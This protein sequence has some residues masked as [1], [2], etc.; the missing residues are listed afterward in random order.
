MISGDSLVMD[1]LSIVP[2]SLFLF[3]NEQNRIPDS[4]FSVD[5]STS[6]LRI[7]KSLRGMW[8]K[9]TYR[10]FPINFTKPFIKV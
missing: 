6:I 3:D 7:D 2:E 8:L 10:V 1:T 4:L 9:A 5:Y